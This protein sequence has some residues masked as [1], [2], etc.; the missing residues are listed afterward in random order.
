MRKWTCEV[1]WCSHKDFN[2]LKT[3]YVGGHRSRHKKELGLLE[4][5]SENAEKSKLGMV[6]GLVAINQFSVDF[7]TSVHVCPK[8]YAT[9]AT[10]VSQS[11]GY[12]RGGVQRDK[13][14]RRSVHS[15]SLRCRL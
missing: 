9:Y 6:V 15:E 1:W 7:V 5:G 12:A 2:E 10:F 14:A 11:L 4:T 13:T 3:S 8:S